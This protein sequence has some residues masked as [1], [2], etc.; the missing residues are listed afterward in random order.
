MRILG[1]MSQISVIIPTLNEESCIAQVLDDLNHQEGVEL[2]IIVADGGSTDSTKRIAE[3]AGAT[4]ANSKVGRGSQLNHGAKLAKSDLLLFLHADSR[5]EARKQLQLAVQEFESNLNPNLAGHFGITFHDLKTEKPWSIFYMEEKSLLNRKNTTNGDQGL[6]LRRSFFVELGGYSESL[7]FLED[8]DIVERIRAKGELITLP[9]RVATSARRFQ[10]QGLQRTK[11]LM[12]IIMGL[13]NVGVIEAFLRHAP[14][15]YETHDQSK[16]LL[17]TPY[18]RS[19][20]KMLIEEFGFWGSIKVWYRVG[21]YIRENSWQLFFAAD[22]L[23]RFKSLS[24]FSAFI[25]F[26]DKIFWPLTKWRVF[27][28]INTLICFF[29]FM[30]LLPTVFYLLEIKEIRQTSEEKVCG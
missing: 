23:I 18:F 11:I 22:S 6:L 4:F 27:D 20:R 21:R 25:W 15:T 1:F 2:E 26:H 5:L 19:I 10:T 29:W 17:L 24:N 16:S 12:S 14:K 3:A 30:I 13:F 8:Q 28:A 9:G 7:H